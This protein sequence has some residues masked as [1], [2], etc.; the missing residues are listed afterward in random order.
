MREKNIADVFGLEAMFLKR[1]NEG[2]FAVR[3]KKIEK[4]IAFFGAHSGVYEDISAIV[5]YQ[6]A[7]HGPGAEVVLIGRIE[8]LPQAFGDNAEHGATVQFEKAGLQCADFHKIS[9]LALLRL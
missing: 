8:F 7:A 3:F 5:L 9:I 1:P 4:F 6:K 2:V